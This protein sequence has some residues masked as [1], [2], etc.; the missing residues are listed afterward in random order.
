M[1]GPKVV[2]Q[3]FGRGLEMVPA[4]LFDPNMVQLCFES[5]SEV[6]IGGSDWPKSGSKISKFVIN[7]F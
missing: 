3:W 1:C 5:N 2:R 7:W 4:N 6:A